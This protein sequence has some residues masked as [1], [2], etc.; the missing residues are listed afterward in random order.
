[1]KINE[2]EV[3]IMCDVD[4]TLIRPATDSDIDVINI[5]NPYDKKTYSYV[6][7]NEHVDLLRQYKGRG[8]YVRVWSAGGVRHA[9]SVVQALG[10]DDGTVDDVETKPMKHVDD[11][12]N[13][14]HII[15]SRVFI[16]KP[17]FL[18]ET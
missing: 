9:A 14:M 3:I 2:N 7:H 11:R 15:G 16:H 5:T 6:V 13:N 18:E 8:F 10:L 4:G 17:G 12:K 1:M